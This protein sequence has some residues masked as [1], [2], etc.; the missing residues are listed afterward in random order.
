MIATQKLYDL[1]QRL[2][3]DTITRDLL[4]SGT[5]SR[6]IDEYSVTGLTSN[7]T[8]FE[9][10]IAK[11]RDY[12]RAI[13]DLTLAGYSGEALF[14]ELALQDLRQAADLFRPIYDASDGAD[15]WVSLEVSPQLAN[16]SAA[17]IAAAKDLYSRIK[18][19]NVLIKIPGTEAGMAA[20]EET[21]FAGIPVNVTLL[22]SHKHYLAAAAAY[23]KGIERRIEA[24]LS[25]NVR[26]VASFFVS[27]W[28]VAVNDQVAPELH[29]RLGI[30]VAQRTYQAYCELLVSPRWQRL[31]QTGALPQQLLWA[32][33]GTKDPTAAESLYVEALAAPNTINTVP[34]KTLLAFA[35][36]GQVATLLPTDGGETLIAAFTNCGIDID[37]LAATLQRQG[38]EA[39]S[40]SWDALMARIAITSDAANKLRSNIAWM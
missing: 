32:S 23:M 4:A 26:S 18:R 34:E 19:S 5:L 17:T 14:F 31:A 12:E 1:G 2:W 24:D 21:I 29:N 37:A 15:G 10:A 11:S 35:E 39:F 33:T 7:P 36:Y 16:D 20:I 13:S 28:D 30:A 3:L 22:F 27:R 38:I 8:I 6:Y 25:P 40:S 9:R